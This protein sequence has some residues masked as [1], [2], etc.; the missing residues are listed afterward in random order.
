M[1]GPLAPPGPGSEKILLVDDEPQVLVGLSRQIRGLCAVETVPSGKEALALMETAGPYAVIVSDMRMPL[2]TGAQLLEKVAARWPDTVRVMLTGNADQDTAVQAVNRAQVFRF[3]NKP[4]S[5]ETLTSVVE[6]ALRQYRLQAV[7]RELLENTL[8]GS[9][10][11]LTETLEL[12]NPMAFSRSGRLKRYV[13]HMAGE[14]GLPETWMFEVAAM[15][16]QIGCVTLD[17]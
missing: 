13:L 16:S 7:E 17:E 6:L 5:K 14:M 11:I 15:L 3:L 10:R 12:V 4:C 2:M 1:S 9:V 8:R